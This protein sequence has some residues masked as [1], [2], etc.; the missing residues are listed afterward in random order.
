MATGTKQTGKSAK[1][2]EPSA[3]AFCE[4]F[5]GIGLV[6]EGLRD[7]GWR[8]V[9]AN[10]I[11]RK[12][13]QQYLAHFGDEHFHLEDV[14]ETERVLSEIPGSPILA[15][16]SF[17]CIDL[18]LAGHWRGFEGKH[19]S[20]FFAFAD[21]LE[22]MG[23]RRPKLVMLEN[24]GG[25]LTSH[26]GKD[27]AS[28]IA[29][30][31]N[32]GY[33]VDSFVIDAKFFVPQSRLRVFVIGVHKSIVDKCKVVR[34]DGTALDRWNIAIRRA[35]ILRPARLIRLMEE[36]EIP[37]GWIA[38]PISQPPATREH[39]REFIDVDDGQDWWDEDQVEKHYD[40]MSDLHKA[41]VDE[42][43][44]DKESIHVGTIYRRKRHGKTRAET[45]FDGLAG[46]L[47]VPRGGSARQIVI[48]LDRG[49]L[50]IRWMSPR[51]YARLQ[52]VPDFPLVG[53]QNQQMAGFGDAVCV[54]VIRWIDQ[55]V[56]TPL[57][58]SVTMKV[59]T[60]TK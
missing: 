38:T 5:A 4:F 49:K 60:L 33:F 1:S 47:R 18:S 16:A 52:G 48:V 15:T 41:H 8:C 31:S 43:L 34:S 2:V 21:V 56:L 46:C 22:A 58:E 37:T 13:Q 23:G 14:R 55:Q 42:L 28:V 30:L 51:E 40:M 17:P 6:R 7:S 29:S 3:K 11:D 44:Q 9:Y 10:D 39:L 25:F 50:R 27:F 45:R 59:A 12:K 36:I 35:G 32:L 53:R 20:T 57:Y 19:S 24:V 54:P 26:E